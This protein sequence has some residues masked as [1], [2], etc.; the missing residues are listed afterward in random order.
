VKIKRSV[1]ESLNSAGLA[2]S[3]DAFITGYDLA[4]E[5]KSWNGLIGSLEVSVTL[6]SPEGEHDHVIARVANIP[7]DIRKEMTMIGPDGKPCLKPEYYGRVVEVDGQAMSARA[8][9]L[10]HPRLLG[11]RPDR[12]KMDCQYDEEYLRSLIL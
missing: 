1:S 3:I 9:R 12:T 4:D 10:T 11:F 7:L 5:E 8:F 2:D 6:L